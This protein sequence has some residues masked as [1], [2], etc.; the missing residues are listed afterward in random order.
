LERGLLYF[1]FIFI[2]SLLERK[3]GE[4]K[5]R[6]VCYPLYLPTYLPTYQKAKEP[7]KKRKEKPPYT[8]S[9]LSHLT[10]QKIYIYI[11]ISNILTSLFP[12]PRSLPPLPGPRAGR[13]GGGPGG[14]ENI[15]SK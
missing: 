6:C 14:E 15:F 9:Q 11:C 5:K 3:K 8:L 2:F 10:F 4:W 13:G 7:P 12:S 1:Y